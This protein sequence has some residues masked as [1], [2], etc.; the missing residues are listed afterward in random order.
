M[1]EHVVE[2]LLGLINS[3]ME[4]VKKVLT[5]RSSNTLDSAVVLSTAFPKCME[6]MSDGVVPEVTIAK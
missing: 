1:T 4:T 2:I 3:L 6:P 5:Q